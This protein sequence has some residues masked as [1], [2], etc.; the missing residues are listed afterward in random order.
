MITRT[1]SPSNEP[2]TLHQEGL[3]SIYFRNCQLV[4]GQD[5]PAEVTMDVRV[6]FVIIIGAL[7]AVYR[8]YGVVGLL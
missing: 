1:I 5:D 2:N 7:L 3:Y 6:L 4:S 8:C